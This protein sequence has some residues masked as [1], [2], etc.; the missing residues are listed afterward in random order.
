MSV[1]ANG[2]AR[3]RSNATKDSQLKEA[4]DIFL[5]RRAATDFDAFAELYRRHLCTIY[6]YVRAQVESD[7]TAE[8]LTAQVF[9]KALSGAGAFRA[10]C[11]Y[12]TWL[13]RIGHNVVSTWRTRR[14]KGAV[15]V[16]TVPENIDPSPCPATQAITNEARALVWNAVAGLPAVQREVV[17]L[18][19][20]EELSIEEISEIQGRSRGAV[21]ILL[22][23]ARQKLRHTLED[24]ELP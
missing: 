14:Q 16:E 5:A 4:A 1:E 10:E 2:A 8:D 18:R 13:F 6:R 24:S 22:H 23:R 19:Y 20:L 3:V 21:R 12:R 11:S 9:F 15:V 17:S 7:S